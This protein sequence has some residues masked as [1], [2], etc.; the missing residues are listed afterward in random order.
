MIMAKVYPVHYHYQGTNHAAAKF[1]PASN[2]TTNQ[3]MLISQN[4]N[5]E[6]LKENNP[7]KKT[8]FAPDPATSPGNQQSF[9][10]NL[11]YSP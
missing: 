2:A 6:V 5:M 3:P 11:Y 9:I 1:G 10:T 8:W 4:N 7:D